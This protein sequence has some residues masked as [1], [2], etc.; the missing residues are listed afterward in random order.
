WLTFPSRKTEQ[1]STQWPTPPTRKTNQPTGLRAEVPSVKT[2]PKTVVVRT[3]RVPK[4]RFRR[5]AL[6]M[7][8][9]LSAGSIA[10]GRG[11]NGIGAAIGSLI[12]GTFRGAIF[13]IVTFGKALRLIGCALIAGRNLLF[14]GW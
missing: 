14:R 6:A 10:I 9:M 4:R 7:A 1:K 8:A 3:P 2:R 11:I 5:A 13:A 12:Q